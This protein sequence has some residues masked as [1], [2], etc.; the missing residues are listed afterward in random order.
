MLSLPKKCALGLFPAL[1]AA[2]VLAGAVSAGS[3]P[4]YYTQQLPFD[5]L[6]SQQLDARNFSS[7]PLAYLSLKAAPL[8]YQFRSER[9]PSFPRALEKDLEKGEGF[10]SQLA[11]RFE[12]EKEWQEAYRRIEEK[13][14]ARAEKILLPLAPK[15]S[16]VG[17]RA[18][19]LLG[20]LYFQRKEF[21]KSEPLFASLLTS[22]TQILRQEA[23][24]FFSLQTYDQKLYPQ[25]FALLNSYQGQLD[26]KLPTKL[27]LLG[28]TLAY[29]MQNTQAGAFYLQNLN[30]LP[31]SDPFYAAFHELYGDF[32]RSQ[33]EFAQAVKQYQLALAAAKT[34]P[35]KPIWAKILVSLYKLDDQPKF[36]QFYS[37]YEKAKGPVQAYDQDYMAGV[38]WLYQKKFP[39]AQK[40]LTDAE[41]SPAFLPLAMLMA[42]NL[43]F[44]ESEKQF[45]TKFVQQKQLAPLHFWLANSSAYLAAKVGRFD[46]ALAL[47]TPYQKEG[48]MNF[49]DATVARALQTA[50]DA[51][52]I[53]NYNFLLLSLGNRQAIEKRDGR[54]EEIA[55]WDRLSSR[56]SPQFPYKQDLE[57]LNLEHKP[58]PKNRAR[59]RAALEGKAGFDAS[60]NK[61]AS[62]DRAY[63]FLPYAEKLQV[64]L[65]DASGSSLA[66]LQL[67]SLNASEALQAKQENR[68]Q[69]FQKSIQEI[70][71]K[72]E[73][74]SFSLFFLAYLKEEKLFFE[75]Y[76]KNKAASALQQKKSF[77]L[78]LE[79]L[80]FYDAPWDNKKAAAK[81]LLAGYV[82]PEPLKNFA[83]FVQALA[84]D[85][86]NATTEPN[87]AALDFSDVFLLGTFAFYDRRHDLAK[88]AF[89][90]AK[91]KGG[92]EDQQLL[93]SYNLW[94]NLAASNQKEAFFQEGHQL[95]QKDLPPDFR[96]KVFLH[97]AN[98]YRYEQLWDTAED[99]YSNYF[100]LIEPYKAKV[101]LFWLG[102]ALEKKD[103]QGANRIYLAL[104]D[105]LGSFSL[106]EKI[107]LWLLRARSLAE[108]GEESKAEALYKAWSLPEAWLEG[109]TS[110][111]KQVEVELRLAGLAWQNSKNFTRL[112]PLWQKNQEGRAL[113]PVNFAENQYYANYATVLGF[114]F[115]FYKGE[116]NALNLCLEACVF[117]DFS[118]EKNALHQVAAAEFAQKDYKKAAQLEAKALFSFP[119]E[120]PASKEDLATLQKYLKAANFKAD[121]EGL[122]SLKTF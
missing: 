118:L 89:E 78:L 6:P 66:R 46:Q 69:D 21:A 59:L 22:K 11:G 93:A 53:N 7:L 103:Y 97:L 37:L 9:D 72:R 98:G 114:Y 60:G 92:P 8:Y 101:G 77:Y 40:K 58:E 81:N 51:T 75:V 41:R 10:F 100:Q 27:G 68:Q 45:W 85:A 121:A 95:L 110:F 120:E 122:E 79:Q 117:P 38:F 67:R 2:F 109:D 113:S 47:L 108:S 49:S 104:A 106:E 42:E 99:M 28:F 107:D 14:W 111:Y 36:L 105:K 50:G 55:A 76:Q 44:V 23:L 91:L 82:W 1:A 87:W 31:E 63:V 30:A 80:F 26:G 73:N 119:S 83:G 48:S 64:W 5:I 35:T 12:G 32:L 52:S 62:K 96:L 86:T 84:S 94:A 70:I 25:A 17:E 34:A 90:Q 61:L 65:A 54:L 29:K 4:S 19:L 24:Y 71:S 16:L 43:A 102:N 56:F 74:W 18:K 88:K 3:L 116:K 15:N 112:Y 33:E 115:R 39:Q 13:D 20:W 57:F